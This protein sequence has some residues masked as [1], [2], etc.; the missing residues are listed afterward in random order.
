MEQAAAEALQTQGGG[1]CGHF[2]PGFKFEL[3]N[4]FDG[5][6][7]YMLSQV[8]HTAIRVDDNSFVLEKLPFVCRRHCTRFAH[9]IIVLAT[10]SQH[11]PNIHAKRS[12]ALANPAEKLALLKTQLTGE[13]LECLSRCARGISL[14]FERLEIVDA[15]A[16]AGYAEKGVA[17]VVTVT[18]K[19]QQYLRTYQS[20]VALPV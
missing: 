13:Q 16:A 8:E 6:G 20:G 4:H 9:G 18:V 5:N 2:L 11:M 15:L 19:G 7:Q 3:A 14:R 17:G 1:D 10:G 12:L